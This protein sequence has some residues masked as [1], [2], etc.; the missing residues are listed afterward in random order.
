M[1]CVAC[2]NNSEKI[3]SALRREGDGAWCLRSGNA[4]ISKAQRKPEGKLTTNQC[5]LFVPLL[6]G[7]LNS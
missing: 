1:A 3:G 7:S 5:I 6:L 2:T 4:G